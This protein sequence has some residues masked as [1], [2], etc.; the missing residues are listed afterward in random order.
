MENLVPM[1]ISMI[2]EAEN[3]Q[4][5]WSAHN[6]N[7]TAAPLSYTLLQRVNV[8]LCILLLGSVFCP[9]GVAVWHVAISAFPLH[10]SDYIREERVLHICF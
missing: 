1:T 4:S 3:E 8:S 9:A 6:V 5:D 7:H 10:F 2:S